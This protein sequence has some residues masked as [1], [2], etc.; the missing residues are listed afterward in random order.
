M[1][2]AEF[3][4]ISLFPMLLSEILNQ[5]YSS[6]AVLKFDRAETLGAVSD[7]I[8]FWF[9]FGNFC[10]EKT[11]VTLRL[12]KDQENIYSNISCITQLSFHIKMKFVCPNLSQSGL[13]LSFHD[14]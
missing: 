2:K 10:E 8:E 13:S 14:T 3:S 11:Q 4:T 6:I 1:V 12:E 9:I 5:D 7:S